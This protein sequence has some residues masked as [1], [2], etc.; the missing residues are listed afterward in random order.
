MSVSRWANSRLDHFF[1][2]NPNQDNF[3]YPGIPKTFMFRVFFSGK[4][5]G[6]IVLLRLSNSQIQGTVISAALDLQSIHGFC[7]W[8]MVPNG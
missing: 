5:N 2:D 6:S 1:Q 7:K 3:L 8:Y 4:D